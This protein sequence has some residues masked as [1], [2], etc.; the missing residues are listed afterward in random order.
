M[1]G[2]TAGKKT[3]LGRVDGVVAAN[4]TAIRVC[5]KKIHPG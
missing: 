4:E 1:V 5:V 3:R 2:T